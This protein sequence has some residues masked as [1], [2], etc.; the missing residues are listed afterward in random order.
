[1]MPSRRITMQDIADACGLSRNT[2][3]KV[4]N[5]R[6]TVPQDTR[7]LVLQ[8]AKELGYG[9]SADETP[10]SPRPVGHIALLTRY[11]PSQL[12]YGTLFLSSFTDLISREGYTLKIYEIS[13]EELE[14]KQFPPHF[15][16]SQIAGIVGIE[17]FDQDYI[18]MVC[19]LGIPMVLTDTP[20]DAISTLMDCDRV[21]MENIAG[22]MALI[23][24][25]VKAGARRIGFVGD[26]N[27][28]GSFRERWY[29]YRQGLME[30]GLRFD[31]QCCIC[32]PDN[33][34]YDDSAW[35]TSRLDQMSSLPDAFICANDYLAIPLMLTLKKRGLSIP[36]NIMVTGFDGVPQS[37]YTDPP[38]TTVRIHG[39][40]IGRLAA[41][42]LL[43]RIHCPTFP[44]SWI[45]VG[46][47]PIWRESTRSV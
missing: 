20:A 40:E 11:L 36:E 38:L 31:S 22:I 2:V 30:N 9:F 41:E 18:D 39:T 6:G 42:L 34:P 23:R 8:K 35:L 28:C 25:L 44:Y 24:S 10:V 3:S 32:E 26:Y 29:G 27:H 1:M 19:H 17:L 14:A 37:A 45:R 4:F 33:F 47:T 43:N 13:P 12:H 5:N 7:N 46:S 15:I 21:T 16:P